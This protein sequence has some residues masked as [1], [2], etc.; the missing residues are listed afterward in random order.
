MTIIPAKDLPAAKHYRSKL[1]EIP[2]PDWY[3]EQFRSHIGEI[4]ELFKLCPPQQWKALSLSIGKALA[5]VGDKAGVK[6]GR[7]IQ[8]EGMSQKGKRIG[9]GSVVSTSPPVR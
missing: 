5:E 7:Y 2:D 4:H 8:T 9:K 1:S 6:P 3:L